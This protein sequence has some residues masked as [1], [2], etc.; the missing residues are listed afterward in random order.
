MSLLGGAYREIVFGLFDLL[1]SY[2]I[3]WGIYQCQCRKSIVPYII[4]TFCFISIITFSVLSGNQHNLPPI[5]LLIEI[6]VVVLCFSDNLLR[7]L[8]LYI[9]AYLNSYLISILI[10]TVLSIIYRINVTEF[11]EVD[12]LRILI[13]LLNISFILCIT[14]VIKKCNI[15]IAI[16]FKQ[17]DLRYFAIGIP[18]IFSCVI[19]LVFIQYGKDNTTNSIWDM[20]AMIS[21]TM[22]SIIFMLGIFI[23][24][25]TND[26]RKY[27]LFQNEIQLKYIEMQ[28][29]YY[30]EIVINDQEIRRFRHDMKAHLGCLRLLSEAKRYNEL[31]QYINDVS[32]E[33]E[34]LLVRIIKTGN[35]TLD[36][37]LNYMVSELKEDNIHIHVNGIIPNGIKLSGPDLCTIFFNTISNAAEACKL[38]NSKIIKYINVSIKVNKNA[39]YIC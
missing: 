34:S 24:V 36:A 16:W 32:D 21:I 10:I 33:V 13:M 8:V 12:R 27:L 30:K 25:R 28:E 3:M 17:L 19:I 38:I 9:T 23:I 2:L 11:W 14:Y 37:V 5:Y 35:D 6:I 22:V 7:K 1:S 4:S 39:L 15:K 31:T 18:S 20:A 26:A 29:S